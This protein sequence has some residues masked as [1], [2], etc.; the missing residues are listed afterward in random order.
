MRSLTRSQSSRRGSPGSF[1][2]VLRALTPSAAR[3]AAAG[4]EPA[5]AP[6]LRLL[7]RPRQ[8]PTGLWLA[9]TTRSDA[10]ATRCLCASAWAAD[11]G[12]F[13]AR[14]RSAER[15]RAAQAAPASA[16]QPCIAFRPGRR[17][18][19][20]SASLRRQSAPQA[21]R[22]RH[23]AC[24]SRAGSCAGGCFV[25]SEAL[26][27]GSKRRPAALRLLRASVASRSAPHARALA[28][29]RAARVAPT[30]AEA[31][32]LLPPPASFQLLMA[33]TP[34]SR[35]CWA[36]AAMRASLRCVAHARYMLQR[37]A[38]HPCAAASSQQPSAHAQGRD[39]PQN[40][41]QTAA[42]DAHVPAQ[43]RKLR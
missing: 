31:C 39:A 23:S 32:T 24:S 7:R 5:A 25:P 33:P 28:V 2:R 4:A 34:A 35:R 36:P 42:L 10:A 3:V 29:A 19:A 37:S 26:A 14:R 38:L 27:L 8:P 12:T 41:G 6:A 1:R 16:L 18:T 13:G 15:V 43:V 11:C 21:L 17:A 20:A 40:R 9:V 22:W 30:R